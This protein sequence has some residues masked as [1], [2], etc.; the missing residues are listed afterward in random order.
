MN[1]K[2]NSRQLKLNNLYKIL[3]KLGLNNHI[4]RYIDNILMK[5]FFANKP[6]IL[7]LKKKINYSYNIYNMI[8]QQQQD[9]NF[10]ILF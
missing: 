2:C 7:Q 3:K 4:T 1:K 6:H 9:T 10:K 5:Y 8:K